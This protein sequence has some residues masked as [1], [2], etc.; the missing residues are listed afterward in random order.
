MS[1][2]DI[3]TV[4]KKAEAL[5]ASDIHICAYDRIR[6]RVRGELI[7]DDGAPLTPEDT[8]RFAF[9]LL[10]EKDEA[11]QSVDLAKTMKDG[12]RIRCNIYKERGNIALAIRLLPSDIPSCEE[13]G[14]PES[15]IAN[16]KKSK[17]LI[18]VTGPTSH[19]KTTTLAALT[20]MLNSLYSLHIITL[21]DPIEYIHSPKRSM[22]NQREVGKD[23]PSFSVALRDSLREDPDVILVGEMRDCET[24]STALTAAETGHLVMATLHTTGCAATVSRIV[25]VFPPEQQFQIRVMLAEVLNCIVCQKLIPL[26]DG[27]RKAAFEVMTAT[28][29]VCSLIRE[30]KP[31]QLYSQMQISK[32]SGMQT[33][34]ESL[35]SLYNAGVADKMTVLRNGSDPAWLSCRMG[36]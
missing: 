34:D 32:D 33:M 1:T 26:N 12:L 2:T 3:E 23:S 25:D 15:V 16:A 29:A 22:V 6:Y 14:I 4:I 11:L 24:I 30:G 17:G 36:Y 31:H 5:C 18:L 35:L 21:E 28:P 27:T 13:L 19:G 8:K 10:D 20:N 9:S 7:L